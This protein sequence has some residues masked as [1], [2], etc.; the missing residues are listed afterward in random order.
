MDDES[1][2]RSKRTPVPK[3]GFKLID[4]YDSKET[5]KKKGKDTSKEI[6]ATEEIMKTQV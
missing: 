1:I 6:T 2:R 4:D 5:P 3:R